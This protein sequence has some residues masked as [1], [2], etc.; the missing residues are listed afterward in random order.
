MDSKGLTKYKKYSIII[1]ENKKEVDNMKQYTYFEF[2]F[3]DGYSL[4]CRGMSKHEL[5][6]EERKHGKLVRKILAN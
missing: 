5:T 2:I 6:I 1:I 4:F 3:S